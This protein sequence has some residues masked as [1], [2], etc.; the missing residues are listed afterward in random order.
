MTVGKLSIERFD[1]DKSLAIINCE[2][3]DHYEIT[4]LSFNHARHRAEDFCHANQIVL[5]Q[6]PHREGSSVFSQDRQ[7]S[8]LGRF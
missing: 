4:G 1:E 6:V 5:K 8:E 2:N 7:F 3:G